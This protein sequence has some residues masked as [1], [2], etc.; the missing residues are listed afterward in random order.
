MP[1]GQQAQPTKY[2]IKVNGSDLALEL[3]DKLKSL[4]IESALG[5]PDTFTISFNDTDAAKYIDESLETFKPGTP[6]KVS[7]VPYNTATEIVVFDGEVTSIAPEFTENYSATLVVSGYDKRH[8]L[9]RGTYT[10]AFIKESDSDIARKIAAEVGLS[11][12]VDAISTKRDH[13]FQ[14]NQS[15]MEFLEELAQRNGYQVYVEGSKLYFKKAAAER[16]SAG[17]LKWGE[18]LIS[19]RARL[20][21]AGQVS[22]VI[23][24]GWDPSQQ[25]AVSGSASSPNNTAPSTAVGKKGYEFASV[26]GTAKR[27][28]VRQPV[29]TANDA[30]T[31][32]KAIFDK[33][34]SEFIEAE[35]LA[36][37]NPKL[38]AGAKVTLEQVGQ[39][40]SGNYLVTN[41]KHFLEKG[42]YRTEFR[43]EG[44]HPH[45]LGGMLDN[46]NAKGTQ[47]YPLW[48]G[49]YPAIVTDNAD[50]DKLN[51]VKLK[52]PWFDDGVQ[53]DWARVVTLGAGDEMGMHWLPEI[54]DEVLVAFEHGN[55]N[56]P[57]V[58]G[59]VHSQ[60][61][62]P[63]SESQADKAIDKRVMK[64]RTGHMI[65]MDDTSGQEKITIQ[66]KDGHVFTIDDAN[67]SIAIN[68]NGGRHIKIDDSGNKIT[69]DGAATI[70]IKSTNAINIEAINVTIKGSAKVAVEGAQVEVKGSAMVKVSAPMVQIG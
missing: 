18:S 29:T 9:M 19:F 65:I 56:H 43:V 12:Q 4:S 6:I 52:Y 10:R 21:A 31:L 42:I 13:V 8:R 14:D 5:Y 1:S 11:P 59:G 49:I 20:S 39:K 67:K 53:S 38:V 2:Y 62:K 25:R 35:G 24:R 44:T 40:F 58:L 17:T 63:S 7:F 15:N 68:S 41:A 60:K 33:I 50:P 36:D 47:G 34:N 66:S 57:Y 55:F 46:G 27:I 70:E 45:L 3:M 64:S 69:I 61:L 30:Q 16:N 22:E 23:V 28:E 51:R 48:A 26:F 37:G 32:A 54:N